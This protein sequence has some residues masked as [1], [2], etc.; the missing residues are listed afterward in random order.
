M[1]DK[2]LAF[3]QAEILVESVVSKYEAETYASS[4]ATFTPTDQHIDQ[5][6]RVADWLLE[7]EE[8]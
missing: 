2:R 4:G 1:M 6:I 3:S 7:N 5:I 8:N